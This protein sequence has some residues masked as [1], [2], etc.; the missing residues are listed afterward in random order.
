MQVTRR[1]YWLAK[2]E[3]NRRRGRRTRRAL[4]WLGYRLLVVW[5]CQ[6]RDPAALQR[7]VERF[8]RLRHIGKSTRP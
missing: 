6:L 5:E 1:G 7:R 8:L 4:Q 2:I 3:R